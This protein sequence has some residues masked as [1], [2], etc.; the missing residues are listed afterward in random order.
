MAI[1][2]PAGFFILWSALFLSAC[3]HTPPQNRLESSPV[4]GSA[5]FEAD[6]AMPIIFVTPFP[7]ASPSPPPPI[8]TQIGRDLNI[9]LTNVEAEV[10]CVVVGGICEFVVPSESSPPALGSPAPS[11]SGTPG[12]IMIPSPT[13]APIPTPSPQ[14]TP[15][16]TPSRLE[17]IPTPTPVQPEP[18]W[19]PPAPTP[20]PTPASGALGPVPVAAFAQSNIAHEIFHQG[21]YVGILSQDT[22]QQLV[23]YRSEDSGQNFMPIPL[24]QEATRFKLGQDP[25]GAWLMVWQQGNSLYLRRST[26]K[27]LTWGAP[28]RVLANFEA[29]LSEPNFVTRSGKTWLVFNAQRQ[30]WA[31]TEVMMTH[32]DAGY[33]FAPPVRVTQDSVQNDY[34]QIA[35]TS[36]AIYVGW[37]DADSQKL[38]LSLSKD[39]GQSFAEP[40]RV[41]QSEAIMHISA[42]D[43]ATYQDKVFFAYGGYLNHGNG[44]YSYDLFFNRTSDG[45]QFAEVPISEAQTGEQNRPQL[46]VN[47]TGTIYA[48]WEDSRRNSPA[49]AYASSTDLG[50]SF[51][52]E[53]FLS[54]QAGYS[55]PRLSLDPLYPA[56]L[57]LSTRLYNQNNGVAEIQFYRLQP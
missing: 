57:Y 53:Q 31:R 26:N 20:E 1:S 2:T 55:L 52:T 30:E 54:T 45:S 12:P 41:N 11:A 56:T 39:S 10:L 38:M 15:I 21:A 47:P 48:F 40:V 49:I 19:T 32:F 6:L 17:P 16:P 23:L 13:L 4:P 22:S 7:S 18:E 9:D 50:A 37:L 46:I 36:Q 34:P 27:G 35:V 3:T 8:G 14:A 44:K 28:M 5:A 29:N 25:T 51:G 33:D 43:I 42:F 24:N